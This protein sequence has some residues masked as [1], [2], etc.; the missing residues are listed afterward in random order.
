MFNNVDGGGFSKAIEE[1]RKM[2]REP[3][4]WFVALIVLL[5]VLAPDG[6]IKPIE[7]Q[8]HDSLASTHT[9]S[10]KLPSSHSD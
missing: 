4:L 6:L 2:L 3:L 9:S 8:Q 1:L 7:L 10:E 5:Y